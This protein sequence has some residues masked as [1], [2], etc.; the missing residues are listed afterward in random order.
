MLD[1]KKYLVPE[2]PELN[3][4]RDLKD[5]ELIAMLESMLVI[6]YTE[7]RL[8][9]RICEKK[10]LT[11]CHLYIG[12]EGV[13]VGACKALR[14]TDYVFSTHRSHGHYLAKGGNVRALFAEIYC[15][16]T[17]CSGGRGGS[18]HLC[19]PSVG[20]LGSSTIVA[21]GLGI[22]IGSA[23]GSKRNKPQ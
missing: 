10:I 18:M 17:G 9:S 21:G 19:D 14:L 5:T 1:L 12:H 6:R 7:E 23:L 13:A 15:K 22:G 16:E 11:P 20:L 2:K 3:N 8:A 4:S